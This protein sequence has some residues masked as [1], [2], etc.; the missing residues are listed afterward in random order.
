MAEAG[1][2]AS[3]IPT[4]SPPPAQPNHTQQVQQSA[5]PTQ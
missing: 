4:P 2:Q 1:P 3:D 5:Q